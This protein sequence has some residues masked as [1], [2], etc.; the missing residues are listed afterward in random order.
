MNQLKKTAKTLM[1]V[2]RRPEDAFKK[3]IGNEK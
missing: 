1:G 2:K 3:E